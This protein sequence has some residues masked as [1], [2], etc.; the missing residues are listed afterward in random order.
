METKSERN[1]KRQKTRRVT[2]SRNASQALQSVC[3][4][5]GG[6]ADIK[7][8]SKVGQR[9]APGEVRVGP[10]RSPASHIKKALQGKS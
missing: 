1:R 8:W 4:W 5:G 9:R 2:R 3:V 7:V 6:G 10:F